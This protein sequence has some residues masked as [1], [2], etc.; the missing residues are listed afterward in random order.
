MMQN[1][2]LTRTGNQ[3]RHSALVGSLDS[4]TM[5]SSLHVTAPQ[6]QV[7]VWGKGRL[8]WTQE[9]PVLDGFQFRH[10]KQHC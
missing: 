10:A 1:G 6:R 2:S 8:V 7:P 9:T 4:V 5:T 3:R